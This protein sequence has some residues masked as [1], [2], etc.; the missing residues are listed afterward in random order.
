MKLFVTLALT[1]LAIPATAQTATP[2][3]KL[4][5]DQAASSLQEA[6]SYTYRYYA[7]GSATGVVLPSVICV[8]VSSPFVCQAPFPAFTPTDHTLTVSASNAA[9]ESL[10]SVPLPFKF[11][12]VP[13]Q[14]QNPRIIP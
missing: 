4:G 5:W 2:T 7:D 12:V 10:P 1:L 6:T 14:P 8:G 3:A 13:S 11:V 9:G